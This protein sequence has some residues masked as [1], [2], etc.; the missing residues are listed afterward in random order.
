VRCF[1]ARLMLLLLLLPTLSGP[2][3]AQA[4]ERERL[5]AE[6][7]G[8][9]DRFAAEEL[10]CRER[11]AVTACVDELRLRRRAAL[12][13]LRERELLLD[14]AER[15][16]RAAERQAA[17]AARPQPASAALAKPAVAAEDAAV[18]VPPTVTA[19][20]REPEPSRTGGSQTSR[21]LQAA[22]RAR[23][24]AKRADMLDAARTELSRK[25]AERAATG[26]AASALPTPALASAPAR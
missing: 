11:F 6:R 2:A 16:Q 13:P 1:I 3:W 5:V 7:Q 15:Q 18:R 19:T 22:E 14:D 24:A 17:R 12:E 25:S 10:A 9:V 8:L 20:L 21:A 4:T 26:K 23:A